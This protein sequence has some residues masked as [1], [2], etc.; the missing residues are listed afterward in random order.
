MGENDPYNP[1]ATPDFDEWG[2]DSYWSMDQWLIWH[3]SLLEAF[4][5][6]TA[7][8]IWVEAWNG[9]SGWGT[10]GDVRYDWVA[11]NSDF[12]DYLTQHKTSGGITMLAAIQNPLGSLMGTGTDV[13]ASTTTAVI[14][15][16]DT[17]KWLLPVAI[18]VVVAAAVFIL[19]TKS[20]L[21]KSVS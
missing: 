18:I 14:N 2:P 6:P 1:N 4:G 13:V 7:T 9:R 21:L 10:V 12:R 3:Q 15:A 20:N 11:L 5:S 8:N 17:L 19:L 16:T